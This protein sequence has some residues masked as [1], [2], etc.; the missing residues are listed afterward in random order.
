MS[1]PVISAMIA[2]IIKTLSSQE[3]WSDRTISQPDHSSRA[4]HSVT[5]S[6]DVACLS[7]GSSQLLINGSSGGKVICC[8]TWTRAFHW[9]PQGRLLEIWA[10]LPREP[11][12]QWYHS[13]YL[14]C[15]RSIALTWR[16]NAAFFCIPFRRNRQ[17]YEEGPHNIIYIKRWPD[18]WTKL[19][20]LA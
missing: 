10:Y 18:F 9:S 15:S 4:N 13:G 8:G 6:W 3:H 1:A 12:G 5:V 19:W 16:H 20:I 11:L 2:G 14:W 17:Y 7:K